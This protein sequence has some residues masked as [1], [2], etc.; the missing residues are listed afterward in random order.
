MVRGQCQINRSQLSIICYTA[1]SNTLSIALR[2]K[3]NSLPQTALLPLLWA[4]AGLNFSHFWMHQALFHLNDFIFSIPSISNAVLPSMFMPALTCHSVLPFVFRSTVFRS[5]TKG[6][7]KWRGKVSLWKWHFN[8]G[9][10]DNKEILESF[11]SWYY[12]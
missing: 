2:V 6:M 4:P 11:N 5:A 3:S 10:N 8:C 12:F 9:L 7:I 1:R